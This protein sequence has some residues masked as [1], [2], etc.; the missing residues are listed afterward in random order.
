MVRESLKNE[1]EELQ[2]SKPDEMTDDPRDVEAINFALKNMGDYKL[3]SSPNYIVPEEQHINASQKRKQMI[4]LLESINYI[5][6]G[7]NERVLALRDLKKRIVENIRNDTKR[8]NQINKELKNDEINTININDEEYKYDVYTKEQLIEFEE[9][10]KKEMSKDTNNSFGGGGA[11]NNVQKIKKE[12]KEIQETS[13]TY[14]DRLNLIELSEL[15]QNHLNRK[16]RELEYEKEVVLE[17]I[18]S[19]IHTFDAAVSELREEK[20]KLMNDL[21][22]TDL[23]FLTLLKELAVLSDFEDGEIALNGKLLKSRTEKAQV[24]VDLTE[25]QE[26]LSSKLEEIRL[27][28]EKDRKL[29]KEFD[30]IVGERNP[31]YD[32]LKKIYNRRIKRRNKKKR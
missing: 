22:L 29:Q 3:K 18:N 31:F 9:I 21:K 25:C 5:K 11:S 4:L 10:L 16:W 8:L 1:L 28:Q 15:E 14:Q 12:K 30:N 32:E 19:T 27:W 2:N 20:Y 17:K 24:V 13:T 26:G 7:L 6:M 23:K